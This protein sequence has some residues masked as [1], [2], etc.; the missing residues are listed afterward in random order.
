MVARDDTDQVNEGGEAGVGDGA[1]LVDDRVKG[2]VLEKVGGD[3]KR[4]RSGAF[5]HFFEGGHNKSRIKVNRGRALAG[6]GCREMG[7]WWRGRVRGRVETLH[8]GKI[9]ISH[10]SRSAGGGYAGIGSLEVVLI[11]S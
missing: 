1:I 10:R 3:S 2:V 7:K 4:T 6:R 5:V 8:N 9:S 11:S